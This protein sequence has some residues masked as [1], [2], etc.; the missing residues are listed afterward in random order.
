MD[1]LDKIIK[2]S[3][4][5]VLSEQ[6]ENHCGLLLEMATFGTEKW[7][8]NTYKIAVHGASTKDRPTPHI[9]LY[10]NNDVQPYNQFNF[11]ISFEDLL[12]KDEINLI[13]QLDRKKHIKKVGRENCSWEG[14]ADVYNGFKEFLASPSVSKRYGS[15]MDNLDRAIYEWNR[16]TDFQKTEMAW[17]RMHLHY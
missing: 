2:E 4:K 11:E 8:K 16:E 9:H 12:C 3:I 1:K 10:L 7:G 14:Y 15:F 6:M 5:K 17:C 13:Y